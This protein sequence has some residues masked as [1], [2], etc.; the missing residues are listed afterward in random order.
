MPTQQKR[1]GIIVI[2]H[3]AVNKLKWTLDRI[4]KAVW[5]RVEEVFLFDDCS[6]ANTY[7]AAIGYEY[8]K[9][10][11][12][13]AIHGNRQNLRY[14]GNQKAGYNTLLRCQLA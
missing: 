3:N 6:I 8:T 10:L 12:R 9:Q 5:D 1:I 14:G 11:D 7:Y 4:P 2:V 13:L